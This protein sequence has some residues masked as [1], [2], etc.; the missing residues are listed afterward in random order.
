MTQTLD[1]Q[2]Q[3]AIILR[4]CYSARRA[5]QNISANRMRLT[6]CSL[7]TIVLYKSIASKRI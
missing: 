7:L 5:A 1:I 6:S 3:L 2:R 4:Y